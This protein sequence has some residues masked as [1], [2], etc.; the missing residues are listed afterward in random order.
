MGPRASASSKGS[1]TKSRPLTLPSD[2]SPEW[3]LSPG[4]AQPVAARLLANCSR[5]ARR[6]EGLQRTEGRAEEALH[7]LHRDLRLGLVDLRL[8]RAA[9]AERTPSFATALESR[10][11]SLRKAV[12]EVRDLDVSIGLLRR[13]PHEGH[14]KE[15]GEIDRIRRDLERTAAR[16]R[17]RLVTR[18]SPTRLAS[19]VRKYQRELS[20]SQTQLIEALPEPLVRAVKRT[21]QKI[22]R[23][24]HRVRSRPSGGRMHHLRTVSY[25]HLTLPT[26]CSV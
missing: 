19:D 2:R 17:M 11:R 21:R 8:T 5:L 14:S 6:I 13:A 9:L 1:R 23:S 3:T 10:L 18:A 15:R 16:A 7:R 25:T 20:S 12:G 24:L 22:A 26:I 4:P